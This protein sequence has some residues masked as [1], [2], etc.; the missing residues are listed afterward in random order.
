MMAVWYT[1]SSLLLGAT[2]LLWL[3]S[4]WTLA[5]EEITVDPSSTLNEGQEGESD[6]T[7]L[8]KADSPYYNPPF[9]ADNPPEPHYSKSGQRLVTLNELAAHSSDGPLK[10]IMLAIMGKVYDVDKG[11]TYGPEGGYNFFTG[12]DGSRA[13]VTGEFDDDG[14]TDDLSGLTPLQIS[15]I[16]DWVGFYDKEYTYVGK[17]IGRFYDEVGNPTKAWYNYRKALDEAAKIKADEDAD[18]KKFPPCN[19]RF[20]PQDG[21]TVFCSNKR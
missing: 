16:D 17:L 11:R 5:E 9:D 15:D 10:P 21:G 13:F 3:E 20:T 8:K 18:K 19:S 2:L 7:T 12:R 14:L 4:G 6:E 1:V